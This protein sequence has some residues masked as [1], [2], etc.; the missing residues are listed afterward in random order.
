MGRHALDAASAA[1]YNRHRVIAA[2]F[3]RDCLLRLIPTA[4][5]PLAFWWSLLLVTVPPVLA[6]P[7]GRFSFVLTLNNP[8]TELSTGSVNGAP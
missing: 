5:L 1:A 2:T 8:A 7:S 4:E 3:G 6:A